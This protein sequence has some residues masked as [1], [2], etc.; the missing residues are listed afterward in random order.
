M[1]VKML[2]LFAVVVLAPAGS[3]AASLYLDP[4]FGVQKSSNITYGT[5]LVNNGAS[6]IDLKLDF[7]QP[8]DIGTPVPSSRPTI[9]FMHG[10][11]WQGGNKNGVAQANVWVSRGYNVA[12]I[13]YRLLGNNPPLTSGPADDYTFLE[14]LGPPGIISEV[15]AS[16]EDANLALDWLAANAASYGIDTSRVGL[17]GHS[18]GAVMSLILTYLDPSTSVQTRAV[19]SSLGALFNDPSPYTSGAPP[20]M[21]IAGETDLTVPAFFV[22]HSSQQ[23]TAAGVYNELYVQPNTAHSTN[24]NQV[25]DGQ[26]L[27]QHGID[28]WANN[29]ALVPE[30]STVV[31]AGVGVAVL[32]FR[33]LVPGRRHRATIG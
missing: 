14:F 33:W 22:N 24:W 31:L 18:A 2:L 17:T 23:M 15:N 7:Y 4:L 19:L 26:T 21:L 28:F 10:G 13:D 8:T 3:F 12:S 25:F 9:M 30:P 1:R 32:F 27:S 20:A 11:G 6:S 29:L 16:I 5:G